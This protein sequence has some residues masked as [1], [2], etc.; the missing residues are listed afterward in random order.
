MRRQRRDVVRAYSVHQILDEAQRHRF[1]DDMGLGHRLR[2]CHLVAAWHR[3]DVAH[4]QVV[5]V[6][7]QNQDGPSQ[8]A[9][10]SLGRARHVAASQVLVVADQKFQRDCCQLEELQVLVVADQQ[11]QRDCCQL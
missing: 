11:C 8:D 6:L 5:A 3:L 9:D 1:V 4:H 2:I 10:L 7:L